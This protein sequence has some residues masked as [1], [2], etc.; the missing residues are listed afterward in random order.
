LGI[1]EL[2]YAKEKGLKIKLVAFAEKNQE[3]QITSFVL[4]KFVDKHDKLFAVDDVFN[5]VKTKSF[6]SDIQFFVGKGAGAYPTASAVLSDISALSYDYRYEYKK[7]NTN[8]KL[9]S[10]EDIY[11]K[12]MLRHDLEHAPCF[13]KYF[14]EIH[15]SYLSNENGYI[16]GIISL[17]H[18]KEI[19]NKKN[20]EWSLVLFE[21]VKRN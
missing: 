4:T 10:D 19:S 16:I 8:D 5:G 2:N 3:G 18:I 17:K 7:L 13:K 20:A 9:A 14:D 15:E 21:V 1:L 6:F 11:L 12:V